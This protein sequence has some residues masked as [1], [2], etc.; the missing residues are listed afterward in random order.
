MLTACGGANFSQAVDDEFADGGDID[1]EEEEHLNGT[2][3]GSGGET[4]S[5]GTE[6]G[7]GSGGSG[8]GTTAGSNSGGTSGGRGSGGTGSGGSGS[9]GPGG[10]AP[11][12][13]PK[14]CPTIAVELNGGTDGSPQ[15]CGLVEDGCGNYIDCE[16]CSGYGPLYN[17]AYA[18]CGTQIYADIDPNLCGTTCDRMSSTDPMTP[19]EC[20]PGTWTVGCMQDEG[21]PWEGCEPTTPLGGFYPAWCCPS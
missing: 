21:I 2:E 18:S 5:G 17:D 20:P 9:G 3:N 1:P 4:S 7:T 12:C 15:A 16:G 13:I 14:T 10:V 6:S 19:G 8:A 11:G